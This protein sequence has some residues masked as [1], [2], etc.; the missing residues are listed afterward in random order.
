MLGIGNGLLNPAVTF[1]TGAPAPKFATSIALADFNG[2]GAVDVVLTN[3]SKADISV[4]LRNP[5]V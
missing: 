4:L 3:R 1:L 5:T 2:D